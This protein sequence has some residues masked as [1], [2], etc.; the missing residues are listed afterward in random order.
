[1]CKNIKNKL[2]YIWPEVITAM[3]FFFELQMHFTVLFLH[4]TCSYSN[5][6]KLCIITYS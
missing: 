5:N 3:L 6:S 2:Q 4:M 1:M